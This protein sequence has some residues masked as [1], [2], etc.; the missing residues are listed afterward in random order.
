MPLQFTKSAPAAEE[1]GRGRGERIS[2]KGHAPE[3]STNPNDKYEYQNEHEERRADTAEDGLEVA[4]FVRA[5]IE[6]FQ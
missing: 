2:M 5:C 3:K 4:A 1:K 6:I